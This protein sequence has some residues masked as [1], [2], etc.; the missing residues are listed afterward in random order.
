MAF[1][2]KNWANKA[3]CGYFEYVTNTWIRY[4][5]YP[6]LKNS[7]W[8]A[9]KKIPFFTLYLREHQQEIYHTLSASNSFQSYLGI[10]K[11]KIVLWILPI[12]N[13]V[14]TTDAIHLPEKLITKHLLILG[15]LD[16][17]TYIR[18]YSIHQ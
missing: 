14:K 16:F 5:G 15:F 10:H 3:V 1:P 9:T 12:V 18:N 17:T 8:I 4:S 11:A 2:V 7:L 6:F 13:S